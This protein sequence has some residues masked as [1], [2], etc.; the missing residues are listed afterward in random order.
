VFNLQNGMAPQQ[1]ITC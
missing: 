1:T